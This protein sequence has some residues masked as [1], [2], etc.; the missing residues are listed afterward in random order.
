MD[1]GLK[2]YMDPTVFGTYSFKI[3]PIM[4]SDGSDEGSTTTEGFKD[5]VK[6]RYTIERI[7]PPMPVKNLGYGDGNVVVK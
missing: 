2:A 4:S 7:P 3:K 5:P 6:L 1:E